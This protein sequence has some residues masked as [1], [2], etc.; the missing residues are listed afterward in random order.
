MRRGVGAS[1]SDFEELLPLHASAV[2]VNRDH[3]DA[4]AQRMKKLRFFL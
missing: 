1:D 4:E 3:G 2:I